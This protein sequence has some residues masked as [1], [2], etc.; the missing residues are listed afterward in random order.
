MIALACLTGIVLCPV[1]LPVSRAR[2]ANWIAFGYPR[3]MLA[4]TLFVQPIILDDR[5]HGADMLAVFLDDFEVGA[6]AGV[7]GRVRELALREDGDAILAVA[8]QRGHRP[9]AVLIL[10]ASITFS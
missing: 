9:C 8:V 2:M 7:F 1:R 3:A 10:S 4:A 6:S 5:Q